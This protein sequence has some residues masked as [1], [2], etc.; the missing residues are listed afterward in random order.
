MSCL[1]SAVCLFAFYATLFSLSPLT[2]VYAGFS[3]CLQSTTYA[4]LVVTITSAYL[5]TLRDVDVLKYSN[6]HIVYESAHGPRV[7][8][9][10][11]APSTPSTYDLQRLLCCNS[12]LQ[13]HSRTAVSL[14]LVSFTGHARPQGG[15]TGAC[16]SI[17]FL[18]F[19]PRRRGVR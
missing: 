3:A 10:L 5:P 4:G 6:N 2:I 11:F 16:P 15:G 19:A 14:S 1:C 18:R 13:Y 7:P 17:D 8:G 12:I 9:T